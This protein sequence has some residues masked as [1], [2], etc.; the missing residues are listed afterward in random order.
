MKLEL[1]SW[2]SEAMTVFS[3]DT[4][5]VYTSERN[6]RGFGIYTSQNS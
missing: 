6:L 3:E 2:R 5:M 1:W 4:F